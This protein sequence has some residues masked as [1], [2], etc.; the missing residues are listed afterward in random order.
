M[1]LCS[2]EFLEANGFILKPFPDGNYWLRYAHDDLFLQLNENRDYATLFDNMWV[3]DNLTTR[4]VEY[5]IAV[6]NTKFSTKENDQ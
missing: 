5:T 2:V 1:E 3:E 4:E 6:F